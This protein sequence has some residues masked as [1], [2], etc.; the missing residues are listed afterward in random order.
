MWLCLAYLYLSGSR[1]RSTTKISLR[2][3]S[4]ILPVPIIKTR[5]KQP[6]DTDLW[7]T[8]ELL[9]TDK[10]RLAANFKSASQ[11]VFKFNHPHYLGDLLNETCY[12]ASLNLIVEL[13]TS[14]HCIR[15]ITVVTL[16]SCGN[17]KSGA[18]RVCF[19]WLVGSIFCWFWLFMCLLSSLAV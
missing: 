12:R 5:H 14:S 7:G 3:R 2:P 18:H 4:I 15:T 16:S 13:R 1:F 19:V 6:K 10:A 17:R 9:G 8:R 11:I